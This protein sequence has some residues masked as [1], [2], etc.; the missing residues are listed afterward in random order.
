MLQWRG[1]GAGAAAAAA[2]AVL[3]AATSTTTAAAAASS[4]AARRVQSPLQWGSLRGCSRQRP[5]R[6]CKRSRG[7]GCGRVT[8]LE[9]RRCLA[10]LDRLSRSLS[11]RPLGAR[12][13]LLLLELLLAKLRLLA[14]AWLAADLRARLGSGGG[15]G[16]RRR[17][18]GLS[19]SRRR[20]SGSGITHG[21]NR[22]RGSGG[23]RSSMQQQS[24][25]ADRSR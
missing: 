3:R 16:D 25:W 24:G 10:F 4:R 21:S 20:G 18:S 22:C 14:L 2:E 19:G 17:G 1:A 13:C 11:A 9:R 8:G 7:L 23:R 15:R 12:R 6:S 5:S